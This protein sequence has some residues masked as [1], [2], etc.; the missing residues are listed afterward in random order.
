VADV[1]GGEQEASKTRKIAAVRRCFGEALPAWYV[2]DTVGD[3]LEAR[4][5]GVRTVGVAWGWHGEERL[6]RAS[7]DRIVHAPSDLLDLF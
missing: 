7:P 2:C 1:L 3:V 5:A 6:R 4:E